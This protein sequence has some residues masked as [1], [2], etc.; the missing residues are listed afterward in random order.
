MDHLLDE[1]MQ[2][3]VANLLSSVQEWQFDDTASFSHNT[4]GFLCKAP[5]T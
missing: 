4:A 3:K 1:H 5:H 2:G